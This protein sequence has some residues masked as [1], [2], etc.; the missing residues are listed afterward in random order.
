MAAQNKLECLY[1]E[2]KFGRGRRLSDWVT[3]QYLNFRISV[4]L[5]TQILVIL[6][7]KKTFQVQT[8]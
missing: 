5:Y 7:P 8:L 3:W 2:K 6:Y 4:L 1:F